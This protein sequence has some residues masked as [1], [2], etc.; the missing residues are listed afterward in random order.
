MYAL[1]QLM[2]DD[3]AS[4]DDAATSC[5]RLLASTSEREGALA[6][7]VMDIVRD[8]FG[9][10]RRETQDDGGGVFEIEYERAIDRG[11]YGAARRAA[12]RARALVGFGDGADAELDFESR[13]MNANLDGVMQNFDAAQDELRTIIKEAELCGDEHA[14]MR[15][16]LTL[17]E[18]HLSADAPTLALTRALLLERLAAE[19]RLESIRATVTCIACEAWLALG[20]SHARLARDTLDERSLALL[21][22]D[23][24]RTQARLR[25]VRARAI[26]TT[27]VRISTIARRVV[28]ALERACE[29]YVKLD[30]RCDAARAYAS[31]ADAHWRV[32]ERRDRE[33][34]PARRCRA[35]ATEFTDAT[36]TRDDAY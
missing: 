14:V 26:A 28:D 2:H 11:E 19:R 13:R 24:L 15:A 33:R 1:R 9:R 25:G 8:S 21:S 31:L 4:A 3:E 7:E 32:G 35:L 34:R 22:S 27:P 20:G 36:P 10:T 17:A 18:T 12:R 16:T 23:C 30:A 29:R 5:A 6:T